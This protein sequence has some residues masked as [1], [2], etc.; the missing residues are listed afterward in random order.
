MVVVI[1][2][3]SAT[4]LPPPPS[5]EGQSAGCAVA[6]E[7]GLDPGPRPQ[8]PRLC[9][10][11]QDRQ[12]KRP[13]H[14]LRGSRLPQYRRVLGQEAR[15]LHDHGGHLHPGLR[16]LQR[17]D[18]ECPQ[19]SDA[20]GA[21]AR[22][23]SHVQARSCPYRHH[24]PWIATICADGGAAHSRGPLRAI[25]RALPDHDHRDLRRRISCAQG[26]R[27]PEAVVAAEA[28]T[29]STTISKPCSVALSDGAAG[30]GALATFHSIRLLQRVKRKSIP[31]SSH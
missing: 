19:R 15:H 14:R 1:D 4:P 29:C 13:R 20:V 9:R 12:G 21:G 27:A 24:P 17:Q 11:P 26:R 8:Y 16:L 31:P 18:L 2:T 6:A 10:H 7:A 3:V 5:G 23:R 25:P 22:R 28:R 30:P